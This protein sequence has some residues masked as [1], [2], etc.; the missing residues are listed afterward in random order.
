MPEQMSKKIV[1]R[2]AI[3][4]AAEVI[5][6]DGE[7]KDGLLGYLKWLANDHPKYFVNLM[8]RMV[9]LHLQ[10]ET[11][12]KALRSPEEIHAALSARGIPV[13]ESLFDDQWKPREN[14]VINGAFRVIDTSK[15]PKQ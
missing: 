5:G 12:K 13:P 4:L 8:A 7:G 3:L 2:D 14:N 11:E 6:E 9:P 15:L 10:V 1:L